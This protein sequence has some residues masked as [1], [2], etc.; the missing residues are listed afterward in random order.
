MNLVGDKKSLSGRGGEEKQ[1]I[2][3][4]T[5]PPYNQLSPSAT[6]CFE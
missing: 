3:E 5:A 4:E 6:P 1:S 2:Q